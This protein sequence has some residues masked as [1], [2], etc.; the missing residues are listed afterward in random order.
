MTLTLGGKVG[1]LTYYRTDGGGGISEID[2]T[3]TDPA[4]SVVTLA[5]KKPVGGTGDGR[6]RVGEVDGLDLTRPAGARLLS[7]AKADL[8]GEGVAGEGVRLNGYLGALVI[9][10][11]ENG[12]DVTLAG[13]RRPS[14]PTPAPRSRPDPG[15]GRRPDGHH[16]HRPEGPAGEPDRRQR[17]GRGRS[18]PPAPGRSRPRAS[19][20]PRPSRPA[21]RAT[22][23]RT[24]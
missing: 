12:A 11:V 24:W 17:R 9:G 10:D 8:V 1:R 3:D 23:T 14:R 16:L 15:D 4:R 19:P 21:S 13:P 18:R 22:S 5:V 20:S 2:L 6:V 7:L